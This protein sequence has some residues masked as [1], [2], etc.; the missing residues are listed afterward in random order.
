[1]TNS[2]RPKFSGIEKL[3]FDGLNVEAHKYFYGSSLGLKSFCGGT[4]PYTLWISREDIINAF[5][6][7][8]FVQ[9]EVFQEKHREIKNK[10]LGIRNSEN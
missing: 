9:H 5:E 10:N 2:S 4:K 8:G 6:M 1:M 7:N 3:E